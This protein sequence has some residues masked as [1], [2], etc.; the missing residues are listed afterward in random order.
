MVLLLLVVADVRPANACS[1]PPSG[2]HERIAV[3]PDGAVGVPRNAR[4]VIEYAFDFDDNGPA[5]RLVDA[6]GND[7]PVT[8]ERHRTIRL[9]ALV[10]TPTSLLLPGAVYQVWDD[11]SVPCEESDACEGPVLVATFTTGDT[12]DTAAP[13]IAD[14]D[15]DTDCGNNLDSECDDTDEGTWTNHHVSV[16]SRTD[17]HAAAWLRFLY[18]DLTTGET[19]GP[20]TLVTVGHGA[21]FGGMELYLDSDRFAVRAVDLAGNVEEA[22]HVVEGETCPPPAAPDA[23]VTSPDPD[24]ARGDGAGCAAAPPAL[25]AALAFLPLCRLRRRARA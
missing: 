13:L 16:G 17:D 9:L 15:V 3:P 25:L 23:G 22:P 11:I 1:L 24:D 14:I 18:T 5:P 12:L 10:L 20:Y 19:A 7:V 8:V 4:V 6:D 21:S 2:I